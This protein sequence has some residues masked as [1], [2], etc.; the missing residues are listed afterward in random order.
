MTLAAVLLTVTACGSDG[1]GSAI[2]SG[3]AGGRS[4]AMPER[5]T[6]SGQVRSVNLA[7]VMDTGTPE[8][9]LGPVAE[10]YPPQCGG[11]EITNW[12][13]ETHGQRTFDEQGDVRWGT[14]AVTGTW[15]G[16]AFE[17]S[18]AI[19]GPLYDA[20]APEPSVTPTPAA[21]YSPDELEAIATEVRELPGAQG[22][23]GNDLTVTV[24]VMYDDGSLQAW[25]DEEYGTGVVLLTALLVDA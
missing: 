25:A 14:Y 22:S 8:L 6:P 5:P 9:C 23:Y 18:E 3:P 21:S 16:T 12:D 13:W 24:E 1:E 10:S 11:P 19:P 17:V 15:D 7:T 20:I 4:S 2:D